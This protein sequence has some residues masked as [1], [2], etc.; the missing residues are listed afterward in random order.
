MGRRILRALESEARL[1]GARRIVLETGERQVAAVALYEREGFTR[2]PLFGEYLD[3]PLS[4]CM[5]KD[6]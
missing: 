6:L 2:I 5:A 1:L 3:S 4:L